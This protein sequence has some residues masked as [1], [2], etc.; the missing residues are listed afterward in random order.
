MIKV[1]RVMRE[2]VKNTV[3]MTFSARRRLFLPKTGHV[4]LFRNPG[5]VTV[6][7]IIERVIKCKTDIHTDAIRT[8]TQPTEGEA[9]I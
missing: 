4:S 3:L 6:Y 2:C 1:M 5:C 9:D 7:N 8:A